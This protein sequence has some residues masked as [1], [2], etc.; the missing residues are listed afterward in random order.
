MTIQDLTQWLDSLSGRLR[1]LE[2]SAKRC[3][4]LI[5]STAGNASGLLAL[6][7]SIGF[8]ISEITNI[9]REVDRMKGTP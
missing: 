3:R 6:E 4:E 9:R 7:L 2:E 1:E 8:I 5:G